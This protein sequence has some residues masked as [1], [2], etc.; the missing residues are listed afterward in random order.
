MAMAVVAARFGSTPS[1]MSHRVNVWPLKSTAGCVC[2]M[3]SCALTNVRAETDVELFRCLVFPAL[4]IYGEPRLE[5]D[6]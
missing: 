2:E 3:V 4:K 1:G 5:R 6:R